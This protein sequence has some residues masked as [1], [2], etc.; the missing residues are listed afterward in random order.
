MYQAFERLI[1]W[2]PIG[3]RINTNDLDYVKLSYQLFGLNEE[4]QVKL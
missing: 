4:K 2:C 3:M 1:E